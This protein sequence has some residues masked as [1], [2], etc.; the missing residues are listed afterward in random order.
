MKQSL[1]ALLERAG[2][3]RDIDLVSSGSPVDLVLRLGP[4]LSKVKTI[5]AIEALA[6]RGVK[7]LRAKRTIEAVVE[8]GEAVLHVPIVED[9]RKFGRELRAAGILASSGPVGPS[10]DRRNVP[11]AAT[12]TPRV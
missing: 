12:R 3:I 10:R 5:S 4:D 8:Q 6:R 9:V 11:G 7:L 2:P 1:R